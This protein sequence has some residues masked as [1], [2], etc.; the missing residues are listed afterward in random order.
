MAADDS[1]LSADVT[2]VAACSRSCPRSGACTVQHTAEESNSL[3]PLRPW[4][5]QDWRCSSLLQESWPGGVVDPQGKSPICLDPAGNTKQENSQT[6]KNS[7]LSNIRRRNS[8]IG[9]CSL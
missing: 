3:R 7:F 8:H 9:E 6:D 1:Q 5:T 2:N 4:H